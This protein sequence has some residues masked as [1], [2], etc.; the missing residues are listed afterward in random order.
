M[1][2]NKSF[3]NEKGF[4]QVVMPQEQTTDSV[5]AIVNKAT[6][7]IGQLRNQNRKVLIL[8]DISGMSTIL[9][10]SIRQV[11]F[12]LLKEVDFDRLAIVAP[13]KIVRYLVDIF[14]RTILKNPNLRLFDT[15]EAAEAWLLS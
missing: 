11:G 3:I 12:S 6:E 2:E 4:L 9:S 1:V 15:L 13:A 10:T 7:L 8:V 5:K 14:N